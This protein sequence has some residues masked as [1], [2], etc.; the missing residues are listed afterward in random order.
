MILIYYKR[1]IFKKAFIFPLLKRQSKKEREREMNQDK[2]RDRVR[3]N[4]FRLLVQHPNLNRQNWQSPSQW[5]RTPLVT[6][7]WAGGAPEL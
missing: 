4:N 5:S 3:K 7:K 1:L 2:D 6:P